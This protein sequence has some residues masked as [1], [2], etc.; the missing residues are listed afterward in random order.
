MTLQDRIDAALSAAVQAGQV[1]GVA[2]MVTDLH[3]TRYQ[4]AFGVRTLGQP[5]AMDLD[6]VGWIASM[7]KA[8]TAAAAMQLVERG[9]LELDAPALRWLPELASVP[10]LEGFDAQG[11]PITRAPRRP[12]TLRHLLT[13]TAGFGYDTWNP[14]VRRYQEALGLPP[15]ASGRPAARNT[16]LPCAPGQAL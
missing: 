4:G 16:A 11:R 10:V 13:H 7:T 2:A 8:I 15:M 14:E 6:T 9:L 3:H 1:P 5:Q 12:V